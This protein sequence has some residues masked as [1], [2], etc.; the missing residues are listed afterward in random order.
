M[1]ICFVINSLKYFALVTTV[2]YK[3]KKSLKYI[4]V[5]KVRIQLLEKEIKWTFCCGETRFKIF[6][7]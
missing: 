4:I 3:R 6:N 7:L 2:S 1:V 5:Y